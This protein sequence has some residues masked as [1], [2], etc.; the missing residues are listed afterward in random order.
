M[1]L[2]KIKPKEG[3]KIKRPDNGR[4]LNP[5]GEDVPKNTFWA[6][7]LADGDVVEVGAKAPAKS[8]AKAAPSY[9]KKSSGGDK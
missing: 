1:E 5:E 8:E 2:M 4:Y 6:R 7:R 9:E 3:L